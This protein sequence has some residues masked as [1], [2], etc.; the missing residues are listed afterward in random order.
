M[1]TGTWIGDDFWPSGWHKGD[2]ATTASEYKDENGRK[3]KICYSSEQ[4]YPFWSPYIP[5]SVFGCGKSYYCRPDHGRHWWK[6]P[7]GYK[8]P[9]IKRSRGG[10][11]TRYAKGVA[12]D[13]GR[14]FAKA[15]RVAAEG[16]IGKVKSRK[17]IDDMMKFIAECRELS[18]KT[19]K[20]VITAIQGKRLDRL[21]SKL[22]RK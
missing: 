15:L 11:K 6:I 4:I 12:A 3:F 5:L 22:K 19:G 13:V 20:P 21:S 10:I 18:V 14:C 1:T 17:A 9:R 2:V 7:A 8:S 16:N